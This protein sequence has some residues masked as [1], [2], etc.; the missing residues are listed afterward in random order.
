MSKMFA[1][2]G[3]IVACLAAATAFAGTPVSKT[4]QVGTHTNNPPLSADAPTCTMAK[5]AGKANQAKVTVTPSQ[6]YTG[7]DYTVY[8]GPGGAVMKRGCGLEKSQVLDFTWSAS[9]TITTWSCYVLM[10]QDPTNCIK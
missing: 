3:M 4:P 1:G 2:I 6:N 5:V 8:N 7:F 9:G 10:Q